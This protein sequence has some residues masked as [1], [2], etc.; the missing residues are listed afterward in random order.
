ML[1]GTCLNIGC[2]PSKALIHA[3]E[4]FEKAPA[5]R[6]RIGLGHPGAGAA[7][8]TCPRPCA[9]R[10]ASS[11]SSP[12][13]SQRCSKKTACRSSRAGPRIVDGKTVDVQPSQGEALRLHCEHLLLATGSDAGGAARPCLSAAASSLRPKRCRPRH[14]PKRLVVVGAGYIGLELGIAY[15]KLGAEVTVVEATERVLPSYD[16]E[17][18]PAGGGDAQAPGRGAAPGLQRAGPHRQRRGRARAQRQCRRVRAAGGPCAGGRRPQAAH[19]RLRARIAAAGHGTAA[20]S[21]STTSAAPRCA[22]SGPS[23]T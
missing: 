15:R 14:L 12:A 16:E 20:P 6:Q 2:I 4:E 19:R 10:T 9:G 13:A 17:T 3:A 11:A 21:R 18:D 8:S 23:A 1:G 7:R 5:L 22:T